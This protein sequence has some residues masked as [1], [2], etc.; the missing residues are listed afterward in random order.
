MVKLGRITAGSPT[1]GQHGARL[2]HGMGNAGFRAFDPDLAHG[3]AELQAVLG[4]VDHLGIGADQLHPVLLQRARGIEPHGRVQRGL[5]A[6]GRQQRVGLL[7]D[8]DL[9]DHLGRDRLHIGRIRQARVGHDGGRVRVH[10]DDPVALRLQ[11]L[12]RLRAPNNRTR[13]PGR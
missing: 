1:L 7:A 11:R 5:A 4:A 9:L 10:Q 6:H 13:T 2:L 12:A 3:V 8:D